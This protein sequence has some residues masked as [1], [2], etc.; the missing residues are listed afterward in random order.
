M[1]AAVFAALFASAPVARAQQPAQPQQPA[2]AQKKPGE[3]PAAKA[4]NAWVKLCEEK[5]SV[6]PE[7][8]AV[9]HKICLTH[10]ERLSAVN[11]MVL[12]SAAIRNIDGRPNEQ[13]MILVPLG[14]A[15]PPG[16]QVRVDD[17]KPIPLKFTFCHVGG[18]AAEAPMTKELVEQFK[19]GEKMSVFALNH[20]GKTIGFPIP[21]AGFTKA[22]EGEPIDTKKYH[23]ARK[24]LMQLIRKRQVELAKK[25]AAAEQK[26]KE[27][28]QKK[29]APQKK[30]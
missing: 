3:K 28:G 24:R 23:E 5:P 1:V 7:G 20:V 30:Q 9:K 11:G 8:L 10:H 12:V 21:L 4:D 18:C 26:K 15:L 2:Q 29:P 22:Y 27:E 14:V 13:L 25:A 6:S 16:L 19:K 17:N